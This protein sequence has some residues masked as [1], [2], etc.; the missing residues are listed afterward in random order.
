MVA[1]MMMAVAALVML[2][3]LST[4]S[5]SWRVTL[6][7]Q[8]LNDELQQVASEVNRELRNS[9]R[10]AGA[11]PPDVSLESS[12]DLQFYLPGDVDGDGSILDA[13]GE[14]EWDTGTEIQYLYDAGAE[15]LQRLTLQNNVPVG[16]TRIIGDDL[17]AVAFADQTTDNT[18]LADEIRL[19]ITGS[20]T[21]LR[22]RVVSASV[23]SIIRLRN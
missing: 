12:E 11:N 7:Q 22:G 23:S 8:E 5:E 2:Q 14:L 9:T 21:T 6:T 10:A 19:T 17:T 18:L 20:R 3:F 16:T 15:Q 1:S 13:L 4:Q